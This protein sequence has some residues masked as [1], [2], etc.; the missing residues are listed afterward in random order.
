[1]DIQAIVTPKNKNENYQ[2]IGWINK[3]KD[4][5][6][7]INSNIAQRLIENITM[8]ISIRIDSRTKEINYGSTI[9]YG[10]WGNYIR[11]TVT[12]FIQQYGTT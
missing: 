7:Q 1:M 11:L 12:E 4:N 6:T 10:G 5:F 8:T 3:N 2:M 9:G